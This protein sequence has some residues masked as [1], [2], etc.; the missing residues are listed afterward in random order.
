M[1]L[2]M[3]TKAISKLWLPG[4]GLLQTKSSPLSWIKSR[5]GN[6][7]NLRLTSLNIPHPISPFSIGTHPPVSVKSL[8]S[9]TKRHLDLLSR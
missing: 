8:K 7:F 4:L 9:S 3:S 2:K 1:C 5:A 6:N